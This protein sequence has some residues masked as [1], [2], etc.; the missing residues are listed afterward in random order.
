[1]QPVRSAIKMYSGGE[2]MDWQTTMNQALDYI[3]ENLTGE[4]KL[5]TAA[6]FMGCS[7][8]EF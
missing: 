1:M 7:V 4:I 5:E 3:E 8:W 6:R 2:K